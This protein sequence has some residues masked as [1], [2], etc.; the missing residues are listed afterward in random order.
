MSFARASWSIRQAHDHVVCGHCH[1]LYIFAS[2]QKK[3]LWAHYRARSV[4]VSRTNM[5]WSKHC[6]PVFS[7]F[8]PLNQN[9]ARVSTKG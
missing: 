7:H 2:M 6:E 9:L 8:C 4:V 3:E 1:K 5:G